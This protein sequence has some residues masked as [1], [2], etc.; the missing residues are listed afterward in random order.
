MQNPDYNIKKEY[1]KLKE[2][3]DTIECQKSIFE[4]F[5]RKEWF[6]E[7]EQW[8]F[9]EFNCEEKEY[10]LRNTDKIEFSPECYLKDMSYEIKMLLAYTRL[11]NVVT[12]EKDVF[13]IYL[14][15]FE[16]EKEQDNNTTIEKFNYELKEKE[17]NELER[18]EK[19]ANGIM[20]GCLILAG[21]IGLLFLIAI[22]SYIK[23]YFFQ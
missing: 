4:P 2:S 15:R 13:E 10:Y 20:G 18:S 11:R 17:E 16:K 23:F 9:F 8:C 14:S 3:C 5:S 1:I 6:Y 19:I 21:A 7:N 22:V 12:I